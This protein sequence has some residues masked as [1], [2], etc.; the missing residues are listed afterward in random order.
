MCCFDCAERSE[1]DSELAYI[2]VLLLH[3][4]GETETALC[5]PNYSPMERKR[6]CVMS[7]GVF[8]CVHMS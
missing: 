1:A 7:L 6:E 3:V 2:H 4:Q 5:L 8:V